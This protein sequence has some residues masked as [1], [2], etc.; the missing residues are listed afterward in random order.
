MFMQLFSQISTHFNRFFSVVDT[1]ISPSLSVSLSLTTTELALSPNN[2]EIHLFKKASNKWS[3]DSTLIQHD[4]KV[5]SLDWAPKTNQI[6]TCSADL[7]AYVWNYANGDWRPSLVLL[8]INRAATCVRWSPKENKFAVGCGAKLINICY[9]EETN[10]WW[11]S[12]HIK[13]PIKSTVT[14]I[15]WHPNNVLIACGSTDYKAKIFS[16]F[17]KEVD[18]N[19]DNQT[20]WGGK[21]LFG[22]LIGEFATGGG[23]CRSIVV[24][25]DQ[26]VPSILTEYTQSINQ[27]LFVTLFSCFLSLSLACNAGGWVH[28]VSFS[29]DGNRLSWVSHDSTIS[30]V[31]AERKMTVTVLKT[32]YL[33][34][35]TCIWPSNNL[36]IAA[37]HD[38]CPMLFKY[39]NGKLEFLEKIDKSVKRETD[40]FSAMRKFKDMDKYNDFNSS[41]NNSETTLDT[42]HQNTITELRVYSS[43]KT[44]VADQISTISLDGKMVIWNLSVSV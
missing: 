29:P 37:G 30:V 42:I 13:K 21:P 7:N 26:L 22:S 31:D 11:I 40:G 28:H 5:T 8:R 18:S 38:C 43:S 6:V 25:V 34:F 44:G 19:E 16:T 39:A 17:L 15:D 41:G 4:L 12:K 27:N 20:L 9:F 24:C 1:P 35:L 36:I 3:K 23:K 2:N 14:S 10:N 32:R 33:P